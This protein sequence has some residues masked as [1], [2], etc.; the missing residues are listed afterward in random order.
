M[1]ALAIDSVSACISIKAVNEKA[2]GVDMPTV[3]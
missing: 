2:R 1:K 3:I